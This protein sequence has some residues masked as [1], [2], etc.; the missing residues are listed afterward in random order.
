MSRGVGHVPDH[1]IAEA[2]DIIRKAQRIV[3][4]T[5]AGMS[6]DSGIAVRK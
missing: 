5:G 4:F 1:A 6:A 3:V 2:A